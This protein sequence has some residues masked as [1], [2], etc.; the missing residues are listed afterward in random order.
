VKLFAVLLAPTPFQETA[1][2]VK[3]STIQSTSSF[4]DL[5]RQTML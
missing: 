3:L 5:C 1:L 2:R 4:R